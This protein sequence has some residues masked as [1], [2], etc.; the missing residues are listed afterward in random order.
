MRRLR[1]ALTLLTAVLALGAIQGCGGSDSDSGSDSSSDEPGQPGGSLTVAVDG[2]AGS[3]D[4]IVDDTYAATLINNQIFDTLVRVGDDGE[5]EP[6]LAESWDQ[7]NETTYRFQLRDG[8][9]FQDGTPFDAE[10]VKWNIDSIRDPKSASSWQSD[11]AA[12]QSVEVIDPLTVE[13]RLKQPFE[14]LLSTLT[15]K[16]GMMRSPTAVEKLGAKFASNPVGTGPFSF[17]EWVKNDHVELE[18][19]EDWWQ[20]DRPY[21][22]TVFFR[23]I[24]DP[25]A[26][27]N[28]LVSGQVQMVDYVPPEQIDRVEGSDLTLEQAPAPYN[29]VV[30]L[31][32]NTAA[33]PM[34]DVDVRRAVNLAIDRNAIV[35]NLVFGAGSPAKSML[36]PS[37]WGL[38]DDVPEIPYDPDQARELLGGKTYTVEFLVPPSYPQVAQVV[39]QNLGDVGITAEIERADWG[40]VVDSYYSGDYQLE[41][42]DS[43]G[44][45]RPDPDAGLSNF[46][47]SDGPLN[48][49]GFA[50]KEIDDL[51][52]QGR[53]ISDQAERESIYTEVQTIAQEEAPFA[54]LYHPNTVRAWAS[55][56]NGV[57][58]PAN[59]V[60]Y[61]SDVSMD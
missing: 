23:P 6:W 15:E 59:G 50:S 31:A 54:P 61:L 10:A 35:D 60:I 58:L 49:T 1:Y 33:A 25:T 26:K 37:S 28:D 51:L 41:L 39:E 57:T 4:P 8:V 38:T 47:A 11:F 16:P 18:K 55:D 56:V 45:Q 24:V 19:N 34:D 44:N 43:L 20:D 21:L 22:D 3:L 12:V 48:G 9:K 52:A 40:T 29:T 32:M 46:F 7:P 30:F 53:T 17:V 13:F 36:S 42:S 27:I 5:Y 2:D 14:P